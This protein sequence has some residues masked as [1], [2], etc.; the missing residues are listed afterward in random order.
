MLRQQESRILAPK[1]P[2]M[3]HL[4]SRAQTLQ[5]TGP[6]LLPS[7]KGC[8]RVTMLM[9]LLQWRQLAMLRRSMCCS[10]PCAMLVHKHLDQVRCSR[11]STVRLLYI[12]LNKAIVGL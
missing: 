3:Q 1:S 2:L 10:W 12:L 11:S 7:R 5:P 4:R 9:R 6:S 8:K